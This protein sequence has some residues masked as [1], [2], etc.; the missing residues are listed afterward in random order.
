M[1]LIG[2]TGHCGYLTKRLLPTLDHYRGPF[3]ASFLNN[4]GWLAHTIRTDQNCGYY[5]GL[6]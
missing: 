1:S 3:Q 4:C 6:V 5:A 2:E